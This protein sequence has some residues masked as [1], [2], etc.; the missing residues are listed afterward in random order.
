MKYTQKYREKYAP[1]DKVKL[2]GTPGDV[3][4]KWTPAGSKDVLRLCDAVDAM[5]MLMENTIIRLRY[6]YAKQFP[7]ETRDRMNMILMRLE[8]K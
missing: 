6:E 4:G 7:Q 3:M 8:G 2:F 5:T 1:R